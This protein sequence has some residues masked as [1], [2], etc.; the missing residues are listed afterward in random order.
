MSGWNRTNKPIVFDNT[1]A[2]DGSQIFGVDATEAAATHGVASPGWVVRKVVGSRVQ[3][4]TL[5]AMK[6]GPDEVSDN[7]QF[8]NNRID[9]TLQPLSQTV[10][11]PAAV[12]FTVAAE[13]DPAGTAI[14]YQWQIST[15]GGGSFG[16]I[17]GATSASLVL[18]NSTGLNNNQ[19]RCNVASTGAVTVTSA[20]AIL[21]VT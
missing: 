15:N 11:A 2:S 3:Y 19:Y 21:T 6:Q 14:T 10:A 9:I 17:G 8:P 18:A 1:L 13:T 4:E 16:D 7:T 12:T 20:A 5:V